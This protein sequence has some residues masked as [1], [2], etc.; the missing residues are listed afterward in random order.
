M[1]YLGIDGGGTKTEFVLANEEGSIITREILGGSNPTDVGVAA[2]QDILG[3]GIRTVCKGIP[4]N[5][6]SVFAGVSGGITGDNKKKIHQY[7]SQFGFFALDNGS[8]AQNAVAAALGMGDGIAVILGTGAIAF[9]QQDGYQ[10]RFG[11]Y[12][13]LL[14]DGGSGFAIGRDAVIAALRDQDGTGP[15]TSITNLV[16]KKCDAA[17]IVDKIGTFY[18]GG[19]HVLASYA[20]IVFQAYHS[21]DA[22]AANILKN[23]MRE[24]A[25]L[26]CQAARNFKGEFIPVVLCGGVAL[27]QDSVLHLIARELSSDGIDYKIGICRRSMVEGALILAGLKEEALC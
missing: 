25:D 4:L 14:G 1:L 23:N 5:Q 22:V 10:M 12:G 11:G 16:Q 20:P 19:K 27:K 6:I 18:V 7:L 15:K 13:H 9:S 21:G 24:A 2:T 26:I 17:R 3:N 8:D